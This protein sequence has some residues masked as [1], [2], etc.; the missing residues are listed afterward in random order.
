MLG[1][2][3]R[4][5]VGGTVVVGVGLALG[6]RPEGGATGVVLGV[7]LVVVFAFGLSWSFA[8]VGLLMRTPRTVSAAGSAA[9]FPLVFLSNVFVESETLPR[10]LE[11]FVDASP[12]S[13]LATAARSLMAGTAPGL[14]LTVS[15]GA[16]ALLTVVFAPLT[17]HL[18]HR[19]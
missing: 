5:V 7:G 13:H 10:W 9:L 18:Y 6:Y 2:S 15:L 14:E 16:A 17:T 11:A 3:V 8:S 1:D 19:S 12:I 4:Y